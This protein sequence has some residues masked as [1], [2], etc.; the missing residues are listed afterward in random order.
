MEKKRSHPSSRLIFASAVEED[1]AVLDELVGQLEHYG[2][3]RGQLLALA[4]AEPRTL[5]YADLM[6]E[7]AHDRP[8]MVLESQGQPRAY[9]FDERTQLGLD[10]VP[11]VR[12]I[13]F[14]GDADFI[15][16]VRPGRLD[17]YPATLGKGADPLLLTNL[18]EG[19]LCIPTLLRTN[20]AAD[21]TAPVRKALR[22]LL[23]DSIRNAKS[24]GQTAEVDAHDALSLVGRALFWRFLIDR[25]L[26]HGVDPGKVCNDARAASFPDCLSRKTRALA[27]FEWLD[28]TFNGGLLRFRTK[29]RATAIPDVVYEEV[30]GN[31][32]H[33]ATADGQLQLDLPSQWREV[34]FAHVPVG[35]L[36]EVYEAFAHD[37]DAA[38]AEEESIYYTPR[39]IAE[40]MVDEALAALGGIEQPAVLDPAAGAGVFL[41]A[42]FRALVAREWTR[43]KR[44]PARD[45]IRRILHQQLTGFDI[46]ESALRLAE[47]ALYLTA[48]ELD[49]EERPRPLSLLKFTQPLR[50][51]ALFLC[52]GG[53]ERGSL[54][55]VKEP[56]RN[57]FDLVIGNPPWSSGKAKTAVKERW[58]NDTRALVKERLGEARS[59]SFSLPD[60]YPDIPFLYRAMEWARDDGQIALITHARWL[61]PG[62][63]RDEARRDLLE[64]VQIT[65]I[66][67]AAALRET[68]VWPGS[69]APFAI[70]FA[71]NTKPRVADAAFQF[72]SPALVEESQKAQRRLHIDWTDAEIVGVQNAI[73]NP[74]LLKL[75]FRGTSFDQGVLGRLIHS[76]P[77]L[78][79]HLAYIGA[80]IKGGYQIASRSKPSKLLGLPNLVSE[81]KRAR[82]LPKQSIQGYL[83]DARDLLPF[84]EKM[85][86]REPAR[87]DCKA[88]LLLVKEFPP[89]DLSLSRTSISQH[90]LAFS[91]S[92]YAA[93]FANVTDGLAQARWIQLL[94]QSSAFLYF[95]LLSDGWFGV[96]RDRYVLETLK[97]FPVVEYE[98][99]SRQQ[100]NSALKLSDTLWTNGWSE[101]LKGRIDDLVFD[102]YDLDDVERDSIRDTLATSLPYAEQRIKAVH[103]ANETEQNAFATTLQDELTCVLEA[104]RER[105]HV[106]LRSE[107]TV[108]PWRVLQI[109]R[110]KKRRENVG[111]A[112]IPWD[113][114]LKEADESGA[115]L[116]TVR[117][118]AATTFV[119]I[120]ENYRYWTPTRARMLALAL[121]SE[122]VL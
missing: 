13:A 10:L 65:G 104:S 40:L 34:N 79:E 83:I 112:V 54:E 22:T 81:Q 118:D 37:E 60:T 14:R 114:I 86:Y 94:L 25:N 113:S 3:T 88:P 78:E 121:L 115:T 7:P 92:W 44:R 85:T 76:R 33:A 82:E 95:A 96:E 72:V 48:I 38:A 23:R 15:A 19:R 91:R 64:M 20:L 119:A 46:N 26:L 109:D 51:K 28:R 56:F 49:P 42:V 24:L 21:E 74:W 27:T 59:R 97:A 41:V 2:A 43:T 103:P 1:A 61:F 69:R 89:A 87:E 8:A 55:A 77:K 105:V 9:I 53:A 47:L 31:I 50:D 80:S 62:E 30:V 116:T 120:L 12:R 17:V 101:K 32:A 5:R 52:E 106:R 67:N 107:V 4:T 73:A 35:L 98:R 39:H 117:V 102:L 66:L 45:T 71:R 70:V 18:P 57:R 36:S 68:S 99:L 29:E 84:A 108:G 110:S 63:A 16:V 90:D 6:R 58:T 100:R 93:S 111:I 122:P 75:R 11:W